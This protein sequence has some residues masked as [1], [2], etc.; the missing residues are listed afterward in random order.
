[1]G[2]SLHGDGGR[3]RRP[4]E[5]AAVARASRAK[6]LAERV[7]GSLILVALRLT[8][9]INPT[10][11]L[12]PSPMDISGLFA[13]S[14]QTLRSRLGLFLLL[15]IWPSLLAILVVLITVAIIGGAAAAGN[16]NP[17]GILLFV[18]FAFL[19]VGLI[20]VW[21]AQLKVY[22]MMSLG[23]YEIAQ[24]QRPD[25]K[26][27][28][29]RSKGY[30][31][32]F[33]ALIL[34]GIA[35]AIVVQL[36]FVLLFAGLFSAAGSTDNRGLAGFAVVLMVLVF[37]VGIPLSVFLSIK[38]LYIVPAI[39][40]EQ[41]SGFNALKRSWSLTKGNFWR[42]FGFAI[43]PALAVGVIS[44]LISTLAGLVSS[45]M[46]GRQPS[47][48]TPGQLTA[49][50]LT[51]FPVLIISMILQLAVQLFT[52]PFLQSYYT[53]MYLDQ[54]RRKEL[55]PQQAGGYPGQQY[56]P[57]GQ[58]YPPQGGR[59]VPAA[60][61]AVP[62]AGPAV[63]AAGRPVSA[64]GPAIPAPGPAIPAPR[65][66]VPTAVPWAG[67]TAPAGKPVGPES[68][69]IA[70]ADAPVQLTERPRHGLAFSATCRASRGPVLRCA[71]GCRRS[72]TPRAAGA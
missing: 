58:Q 55:A 15:V 27:L 44:Y 30:L 42:T 10:P 35:V 7:T 38:L 32:R 29:A 50:A 54:I 14:F 16:G 67:A 9:V 61:S 11:M 22:G 45:P 66:P 13:A 64:A 24:G 60:G 31:P 4:P 71:P 57:Q 47:D 18:G 63:P 65:R 56:P 46:T 23:A 34:L 25:F 2:G 41:Y 20:L 70:A 51:L 40:I 6:Y 43:V 72:R 1:M 26:G 53:Y 62:A 28:F 48:M 19:F 12:R 17:S 33:V 68:R 52:T 3:A 59:A 8:E 37:L 36:I 39:A 5:C 69:P 49:Y 21:L